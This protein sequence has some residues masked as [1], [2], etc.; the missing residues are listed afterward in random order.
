MNPDL[1]KERIKGKYKVTTTIITAVATIVA[2]ILGAKFGPIEANEHLDGYMSKAQNEIITQQNIDTQKELDGLYGRIAELQGDN[3][4]QLKQISILNKEK[5]DLLAAFEV[6]KENL[7]ASFETEK[8]DLLTTI[9]EKDHIIETL[10]SDDVSDIADVPQK[11]TVKLTSLKLLGNN[12]NSINFVYTNQENNDSA[13]SNLGVTFDSSISMRCNGNIDFYLGG[14]YQALNAII[15]ISEDTKNIDDYSSALTIY[16]VEGNGSDEN[17]EV[18]YTSPSLTMGFIPTE[19]GPINVS[20]VEHLRISFY[21][22]GYYGYV[23]RI[24]LGNPV[25]TPQ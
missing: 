14:S 1:E 17:L 11:G 13:K 24:I 7:L 21:A 8:N 5:E 15:C 18:L 25:L 3:E 20:G 16:K 19:I 6:E 4:T 2:T 22:D 12:E 9:A 23:P 10:Q